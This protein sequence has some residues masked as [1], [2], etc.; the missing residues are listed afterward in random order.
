MRAGRGRAQEGNLAES[1]AA[2]RRSPVVRRSSAC[3][4]WRNLSAGKPNRLAELLQNSGC[5]AGANIV[6]GLKATAARR[7][8]EFGAFDGLLS[9]EAAKARLAQHYGPEHCWSVSRLEEYA[10]CPY[11]FFLRNVLRLEELPELALDI[12]Y[13]SRGSLAHEA[14]A[15][16][17]SAAECGGHAAIAGG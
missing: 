5:G 14:L 8:P 1:G 2:A 15:A 13:G 12:D 6:A 3:K 10:S 9:G 7:R 4:R 17:A 11:R 16:L